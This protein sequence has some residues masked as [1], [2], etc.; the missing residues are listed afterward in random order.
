[1]QDI[2][3]YRQILLAFISL[4]ALLIVLFFLRFRRRRKNTSQNYNHPRLNPELGFY[5]RLVDIELRISDKASAAD[6]LSDSY[7][8]YIESKYGSIQNST[9]IC[10]WILSHETDRIVAE[11]L[12]ITSEKIETLKQK[13]EKEVIKFVKDLKQNFNKGNLDVWLRSENAAMPANIQSN[14]NNRAEEL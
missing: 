2:E 8:K 12:T 1:M 7:L 6:E 9:D 11:Y 13:N 14:K 3:N 10:D 4:F 5:S